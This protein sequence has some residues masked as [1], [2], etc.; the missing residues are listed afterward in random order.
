MQGPFAVEYFPVALLE[1]FEAHP[2]L[3]QRAR[4]AIVKQVCESFDLA[5][6]KRVT[7]ELELRLDHSPLAHRTREAV[8]C[9]RFEDQLLHYL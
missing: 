8:L 1:C 3:V 5:R 9:E 7:E 6:R 2:E 4:Q